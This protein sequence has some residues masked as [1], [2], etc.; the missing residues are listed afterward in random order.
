[1]LILRWRLLKLRVSELVNDLVGP[2]ASA[3]PLTLANVRGKTNPNA[4]IKNGRRIES[5]SGKLWITGDQNLDA[6]SI[7]PLTLTLSP[8]GLCCRFSITCRATAWRPRHVHRHVYRQHARPGNTCTGAAV[9][10]AVMHGANPGDPMYFVTWA[11]RFDRISVLRMTDK[12]SAN[13]TFTE[14]RAPFFI[15]RRGFRR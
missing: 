14:Y 10:P 7:E 15:G 8:K 13:P 1:V 3:L 6:T 4:Q 2:A 11:G 5:P 12:L 9:Q